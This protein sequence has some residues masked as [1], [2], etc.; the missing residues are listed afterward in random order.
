[1]KNG[2]V[3][4]FLDDDEI[5]TE[6]CFTAVQNNG[7]ALR[8]IKVG[9]QTAHM[10]MEAVKQNIDAV[11]YVKAEYVTQDMINYVLP[12]KA[13]NFILLPITSITIDNLKYM[14]EKKNYEFIALINNKPKKVAERIRTE[15]M[16][17]YLVNYSKQYICLVPKNKLTLKIF[18]LVDVETIEKYQLKKYYR[19]LMLKIL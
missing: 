14:M 9:F 7:L 10:C 17:L 2:L 3:I 5:T 4:K 1:M 16:C 11:Q 19:K 12:K 8:H 18:E 13:Y 6:L 15:E